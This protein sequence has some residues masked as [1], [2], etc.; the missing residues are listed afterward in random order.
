MVNDLYDKFPT[1]RLNAI[2]YIYFNFRRKEEQKLDNLLASLLKQLVQAQ[3]SIP[4]SV[5]DLYER[6]RER[7]SRPSVQ[8]LAKLLTSSVTNF[9]QV[10]IVVDAL[11]ECQESYG[12]RSKFISQLLDLHTQSGINLFVTTR[13]IPH[14]IE[15]FTGSIKKEIRAS[16]EDIERHLEGCMIN[17]PGFVS[18]KPD[19]R[20]E[21]KE[22]IGEAAD[23]MYVKAPSGMSSTNSQ[24]VPP[25]TTA[26]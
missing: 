23:G 21:I 18:T 26:Y 19:L 15:Q 8:E 17:L 13:H 1:D 24:K 9:S 5:M 16:D 6:H 20:A 2:C 10:F 4:R 12:C 11:D 3:T 14:I 7:R 22:K 25:C